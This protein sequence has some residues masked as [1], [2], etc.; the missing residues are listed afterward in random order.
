MISVSGKYWEEIKLNKRLIDKIKSENDFNEIAARQILYNGFDK[1]EI[2]TIKNNLEVKNPFL[3][4]KDFL[5]GVELLN[6]SIIKNENIFVVG[7][8]DV[9]GCVSTALLI[10]FLDQINNS[11]FYYIPNRFK[12]GY[13]SSIKLIKKIITKKPNLIIFVDNGSNSH[14]TINFLKKNKIKSIIIDHHDIYNPYPKS[15][16]LINPKKNCDYSNYNYLCA[17]TLTYFFIDTYINKFQLKINF[18][19]NLQ[20]VLL[21][22]ISDVMPLRKINRIIG[23]NVLENHNLKKNYFFNK[24]FKIKKI[25]KPIELNDFGFLFGPIIN[26]AG[27]LDDPNIVVKLLTSE[28][29]KIIE[30]ILNK[31]IALNDKRKKLENN[32]LEDLDFSKI[33]KNKKEVIILDNYYISEGLIGIIASRLKS[34]FNK[35][36]IV[37]TQSEKLYKGSARSTNK[38]NIG[39]LIKI[40]LDK[41]I[42]INGGGHNLAAGF[43]LKKNN[44]DLF[45]KFIYHNTKKN[46]LNKKN[47]FISKIPLSALNNNFITNLNLIKPYGEGNKNPFFLIEKV[48]ILKPQL[49]KKNFISC[50]VKNNQNKLFPAISFNILESEIFQN[51]LYN[52][53]ELDIIA[54][55]EENF[56]NNKKKLKLIIIDIFESFNKA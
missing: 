48:K 34:Y 50:F 33:K 40:A 35:P 18:S 46:T 55:I 36:V 28:N 14:E 4:I 23:K 11:N 37:I 15:D 2:F 43:T 30:K 21:A 24:I 20:L 54:Q 42:I 27:R 19:I 16:I 41:K 8:Y 7:D 53:N 45:K 13:G 29:D 22:I 39:K 3:N 26:S 56:W 25:N 38:L 9:D 6:E 12:D 44:I 47:F 49:I 32:I 52:Q 5:N 31:L 10:N 51:L 1:E 17:A